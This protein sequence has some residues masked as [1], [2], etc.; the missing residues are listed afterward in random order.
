[1]REQALAR[2]GEGKRRAAHDEGRVE[3]VFEVGDGLAD[4]RLGA[5]EPSGRPIEAVLLDNRLEDA[6]LV[7]VDVH[8]RAIV[9]LESPAFKSRRGVHRR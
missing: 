8:R 3:L 4:R 2:G 9:G 7:D 1:M 5:V 6:K